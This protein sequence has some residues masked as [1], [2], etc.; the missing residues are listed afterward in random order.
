MEEN[1]NPLR[2]LAIY[3]DVGYTPPEFR[4]TYY[5]GIC[6]ERKDICLLDFGS[7]GRDQ[8]DLFGGSLR[9]EIVWICTIR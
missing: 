7:W 2:I 1:K 4:K 8:S 5:F 6:G 9:V 3:N